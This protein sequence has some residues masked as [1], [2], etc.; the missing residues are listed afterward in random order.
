MMRPVGLRGRLMVPLAVI[1]VSATLSGSTTPAAS[2][3]PTPTPDPAV[4]WTVVNHT[5]HPISGEWDAVTKTS[6][7]TLKFTGDQSIPAGGSAQGEAAD[8]HGDGELISYSSEICQKGTLRR[9]MPVWSD[10]RQFL[11]DENAQNQLYAVYG[12]KNWSKTVVLTDTGNA[13]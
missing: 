13:C 2:A 4:Y 12:G 5:N 7:G 1:A 9:F 6:Q 8:P 10:T 3:A 11:I